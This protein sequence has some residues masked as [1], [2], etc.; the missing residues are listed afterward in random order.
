MANS[1][2]VFGMRALT[3]VVAAASAAFGLLAVIALGVPQAG[4]AMVSCPALITSCGCTITDAAVHTLGTD[5]DAST[6]L[7]GKGDCI[8]IRHAGATLECNSLNITGAGSGDG[9]RILPGASR[10]SVQNC[11]IGGWVNGVEDDANYA[12]LTLILEFGDEIGPNVTGLFLK[13]ANKTLVSD[14]SSTGSIGTGIILKNSNGNTFTGFGVG[15]SGG[16][17]LTLINSKGNAFSSFDVDDNEGNG[18]TFKN[19]SRNSLGQFL[20]HHNADDGVFIDSASSDKVALG[21]IFSNVLAGVEVAKGSRKN[22]IALNCVV[23]S[24]M[25][26]LLDDNPTCDKNVWTNN[27]FDTA[28]PVCAAAA[29]PGDICEFCE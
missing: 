29:A 25:Q 13:S 15:S 12:N 1:D 16:D 20:A 26:G 4:A 7:T 8:D 23:D 19:S 10:A 28:S 6:G 21:C 11:F 22:S 3:L 5:I 27:T 24:V 9:V 17:G 14:F 2:G 18:V